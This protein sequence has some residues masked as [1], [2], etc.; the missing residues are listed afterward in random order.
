MGAKFFN[1]MLNNVDP[2]IGSM[3]VIEQL[4]AV[5]SYLGSNDLV[6]IIEKWNRVV[7]MS[8]SI[9]KCIHD[10]KLEWSEAGRTNYFSVNR[11]TTLKFFTLAVVKSCCN[12]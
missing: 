5:K 3:F 8:V 12:G 2:S 6:L 4:H 1:N 11:D 7:P 9:S 10:M